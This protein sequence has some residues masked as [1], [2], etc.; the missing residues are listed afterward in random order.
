[1]LRLEEEKK[2]NMPLNDLEREKV[3]FKSTIQSK[4]N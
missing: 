1:M 3:E 2:K 4:A